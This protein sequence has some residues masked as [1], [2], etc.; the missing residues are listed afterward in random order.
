MNT[1]TKTYLILGGIGLVVCVFSFIFIRSLAVSQ[2]SQASLQTADALSAQVR[3]TRGYYTKNV[4]GEA[5]ANGIKISHAYKNQESAIPLPATMVHEINK[6]LN[7]SEAGFKI[8]LYSDFPFPWRSN[9]NHLDEF[10]QEA[11]TFLKE[12]PKEAFWRREVVDGKVSIRYATADSMSAQG[13]VTCHNNHPQTPKS[14]WKLGDVRG[15]LEVTLPVED[16][17]VAFSWGAFWVSLGVFGGILAIV[18]FSTY[19]FSQ[20][21]K[22]YRSVSEEIQSFSHQIKESIQEVSSSSSDLAVESEQTVGQAQGASQGAGQASSSINSV[23][24]AAE[25]V[26]AS[27]KQIKTQLNEAR[28]V[29]NEASKQSEEAVHLMAELDGSSQEI[30]EVIK[31]ITS[32]AEQTNLLALN[33]TIEAARA[34][35]AGKGFAVVA[36]EVKELAG[37]TAKATDEITLK[38]NDVQENT[39]TSVDAIQKFSDV[40]C[41][42]NEISTSAAGAA[43]QQ[44]AAVEEIAQCAAGVSQNAV[45]ISNKVDTVLASAESSKAGIQAINGN[46]IELLKKSE[47]LE[48]KMN[49]FI[50]EMTGN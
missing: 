5:K 4:V 29:A 28:T 41:K 50:H 15:V 26:T 43:E 3:E 19:S 2:V 34:G 49:D 7:T 42:I 32:I 10:R 44:S 21:I 40:I 37:Q 14:D 33:A 48:S 24:S 30:G 18:L 45:S 11:L 20:I 1:K 27:I 13:C 6:K 31:V 47:Q 17:M 23:A 35:E 36:N 12:N 8:N 38:I 25:E 9:E 22:R 46:T 39:H 16:T